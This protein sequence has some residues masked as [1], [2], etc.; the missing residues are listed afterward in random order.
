MVAGGGACG[1]REERE[2]KRET[3]IMHQSMI[4]CN[5]F[6]PNFVQDTREQLAPESKYELSGHPHG[7]PN[8]R[9]PD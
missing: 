4:M 8:S 6:N 7:G 9:Y 5:L 3:S 1:G 2:R